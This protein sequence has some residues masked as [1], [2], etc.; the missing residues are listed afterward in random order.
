[1]E[2]SKLFE[3]APKQLECVLGFFARVEAK[4]NFVF[5]VNSALLGA[6][7]LHVKRSDFDDWHRYVALGIAAIGL[8]TSYFFIYRCL[9][10]TLDGGHRSI[11]YF[12]EI[13]RLPEQTFIEKFRDLGEDDYVDD[14][15]SRTWRNSEILAVKFRTIKVAFIA[16]GLTLLPW[17]AYLGLASITHAVPPSH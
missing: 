9:F 12:R 3:L 1:M 14:L 16:T 13:A 4:A 5:A 7:A 17:S 6:L 11:I 2:K 8:A 15:L 10:P